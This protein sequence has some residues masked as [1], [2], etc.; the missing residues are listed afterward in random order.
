MVIAGVALVM[1]YVAPL[2]AFVTWPPR[3]GD[4]WLWYR[5]GIDRLAAGLALFEPDWLIGP[6]N[7]LDPSEYYKW[8]QMPWLLPLVAPFAL[9]P[10]PVDRI[11]WTVAM[12]AILATAIF[13]VVPN[14]IHAVALLVW[15]PS[16]MTIAYGNT[17]SLV[18]MGVAAWLVGSRRNSELY[19]A[20]GI[21]LASFKIFPA[22]PLVS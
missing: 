22:I 11:A 21:V 8:N 18:V 2:L 17:E 10:E 6:F 9:L 12:A 5:D 14:R 15:P 1:L 4:D 16:L 13:W 19:E 7:Y 3:I 20:A